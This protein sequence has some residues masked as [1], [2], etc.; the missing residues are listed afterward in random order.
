MKVFQPLLYIYI[1][2]IST[3]LLAQNQLPEN[4]ESIIMED[5]GNEWIEVKESVQLTPESFFEQNKTVLQLQKEDKLELIKQ[6]ADPLGWVH[7]YYQQ[8]RKGIPIE[9]GECILHTRNNIVKK[10][11][12]HIIKDLNVDTT[13]TL[14]KEQAIEIALQA[15]NAQLYVWDDQEYKNLIGLTENSPNATLVIVNPNYS[16]AVDQYRLAYKVEIFS[17]KPYDHFY[18]YID[19]QTGAFFDKIT[20]I[21]TCDSQGTAETN[22]YGTVDITTEAYNGGYRLHDCTR[23]QGIETYDCDN[24]GTWASNEV[25]DDDNHWDSGTALQKTACETHWVTEKVYDYFDQVHQRNSFDGN[26]GKIRSYV[27]FNLEEYGFPNNINA[28]WNGVHLTYGNGN[29][30]EY[31]PLTA[32]DIIGHEIV[33]ALTQYTANLVYRYESGALNESFSDIFGTAIEFFAHPESGDWFLGE[34]ANLTGNGSRS[35]ADPHIFNDPKTYKGNYWVNQSD[36]N[37]GVLNDYCG[38]HSNSGVQNHWFYLLSEGGSGTNE[39]DTDFDVTGIGIQ[40]AAAIAYRNLTIY[41][42]S[43]ANYADARQGSIQAAMDLYGETSTEVEQVRKAWCAVGVGQC[44]DT[45][46]S[47][48]VLTPNGGETFLNGDIVPITWNTNGIIGLVKLEYSINNGVNWNMVE[49]TDNDGSFEWVAPNTVSN[50][51]LIRVSVLSDPTIKDE[52]DAVFAIQACTGI[53]NFGMSSDRICVGETVT[54]A[55][56]SSGGVGYE[57]Y[58][59]DQVLSKEINA[60]YTA[61]QIGTFQVTLLIEDGVG[62]INQYTKE[63]IVE[64]ALNANFSYVVS[65]HTVYLF[66]DFSGNDIEW[67][68]Q[69]EQTP[70]AFT[71]NAML[72]VENTGTYHICLQVTNSCGTIETCQEIFVAEPEVDTFNKRYGNGFT[73]DLVETDDENIVVI[74]LNEYGELFIIKTDDDGEVIWRKDYH[75]LFGEEIIVLNSGN[76]LVWGGNQLIEFDAY[77][78]VIWSKQYY[79]GNGDTWS[80]NDAI[81]LMDGNLIMTGSISGK[82]GVMKVGTTGNIIWSNTY[83][84]GLGIE[85]LETPSGELMLLSERDTYW[86]SN[87]ALSAMDAYGNTLWGYEYNLGICYS[88]YDIDLLSDGSYALAS[89]DLIDGLGLGI[90]I[91]NTGIIE[92]VI[93]Y[94][95]GYEDMLLVEVVETNGGLAFGGQ[96]QDASSNVTDVYSLKTN[97]NGVPLTSS[98][99]S[100]SSTSFDYLNTFTSSEEGWLLGGHFYDEE[101][102]NAKTFMLRS[103][104]EGIESCNSQSITTTVT[105]YWYDCVSSY[106]FDTPKNVVVS[107]LSYSLNNNS[108]LNVGENAC[109]IQNNCAIASFTISTNNFCS[110][111]SIQ[112]TNTSQN[113]E[114]YIWSINGNIISNEVNLNYTFP[115]AGMYAIQLQAINGMDCKDEFT[116]IIEVA[117]GAN[118]LNVDNVLDCGL[119]TV[120]LSVNIDNGTYTWLL[121]STIVETQKNITI[122]KSGYYT[123]QV[124]DACGNV[125]S[126]E[127]VV[128]LADNECVYPGD[129][130]FDGKCDAYDLIPIGFAYGVNGPSRSQQDTDWMPHASL[131]WNSPQPNGKDLKHVDCNGDGKID[132]MDIQCIEIN[133]TNTHTQNTLTDSSDVVTIEGESPFR[134]YFE[135]NTKPTFNSVNERELVVDLN[136][137]S[138]LGG[139]VSAYGMV[140]NLDYQSSFGTAE[141]PELTLSDSWFGTPDTDLVSVQRNFTDTKKLQ[142]G[143]TRIDQVNKIGK[144]KIGEFKV[145]L[146]DV[147]I[148]NVGTWDSINVV[149][150]MGQVMFFNNGGNFDAS[151]TGGN[152][153]MIETEPWEFTIFNDRPVEINLTA[154][155]EGAYDEYTGTMRNLLSTTGLLPLTQPYHTSPYNYT[156]TE[157]LESLNSD[158]VDWVLVEAR[159][160]T[161]STSGERSTITIETKAGILLTDGSIVGPDMSPLVFE[162]LLVGEDY[163]FCLR[164]RNHLDVLS[165]LPVTITSTGALSY[166]F[167][168]GIHQAFGVFQQTEMN[169]GTAALLGGDYTQDGVI[170]ISDLIRWMTNPSQLN[171]Y[172]STDGNLD[173]VVQAT[174]F[175][176]WIINKAKLGAVEIAY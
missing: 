8:S 35:M 5:N 41:L 27:N 147:D 88:S 107:D 126:Q 86:G 54:F 70:F 141:N 49:V 149:L 108:G 113:A 9:G 15:H 37:A 109:N 118:E 89:Y 137:E 142:V 160:G 62:C 151:T 40:K 47:I 63:L 79:T 162:N 130:D 84:S 125:N 148:G 114:N 96:T 75:Y 140:F 31:G 3:C 158:M 138:D 146:E 161:P 164:H 23:G 42:T 131:D 19:A 144:G 145:I 85:T 167:T 22:Y 150:D 69:E 65:D 33:H 152:F 171:V 153:K 20:Q 52:N 12:G 94:D 139:D 135:V 25:T 13:P 98:T 30:T 154:Q 55:N 76:Y 169:N 87:A 168:S 133:Y 99:I 175:D 74:G 134:F 71:Q 111:T 83:G 123:I 163:Y 93:A 32:I 45:N 59:N 44:N 51:V 92:W 53:A 26:G 173:G 91:D 81:Q 110:G 21:H 170:Q 6:K 120:D 176:A 159:S 102:N 67:K 127:V 122:N 155:L 97:T 95:N 106:W 48:S 36:C 112:L 124:E 17:L 101:S 43:T 100:S 64:D 18:A 116:H 2:L 38:I 104:G 1:S 128:I 58:I 80:I 28:F 68:L 60:S 72:T 24:T 172:E 115:T 16:K 129:T 77:G 7:Y 10:G 39:L 82:V 174:D 46:K 105:S 103:N 157:T 29:G 56:N 165:A 73:C 117:A 166:D 11:N 50:L 136:L 57:W 132:M 34:D 119:G 14:T 143:V 4:F 121:D 156:G 90:K 66:S 61:T 78:D